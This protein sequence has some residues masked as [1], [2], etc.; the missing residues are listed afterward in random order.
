MWHWMTLPLR[1]YADFSGRSRRKEYWL[2]TLLWWVVVVVLYAL[3]FASFPWGEA[4]RSGAELTVRAETGELD[5]IGWLGFIGLMAWI[6]GTLVPSIAVTVR[7]FHDQNRSGW[8]YLLNFIP[9][10][11]FI[12]VAFTER[13]QGLHDMIASTLVVKGQPGMVGADPDVFA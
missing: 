7:R 8:F 4:E 12:M 1:R 3:V 9:Y 11:G 5:T 13:K 6:L 2:Y 10:V